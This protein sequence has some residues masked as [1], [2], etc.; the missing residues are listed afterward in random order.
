MKESETR[1]Y[2]F[3]NKA[4]VGL[5]SPG[6]GKYNDPGTFIGNP[7]QKHNSMVRRSKNYSLSK[8]KRVSKFDTPQGEGVSATHYNLNS[9]TF[10][11][12][13]VN[14]VFAKAKRQLVFPV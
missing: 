8:E 1:L 3:V 5:D 6:V 11:N 9:S 10:Q 14:A 13:K 2:D 7:D 12:L 4:D